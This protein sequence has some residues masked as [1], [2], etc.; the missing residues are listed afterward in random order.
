MRT[1]VDSVDGLHELF[2]QRQVD[3]V[4]VWR[5]DGEVK[6]AGDDLFTIML[7]D[8]PRTAQLCLEACSS[9]GTFVSLRLKARLY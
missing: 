3:Q 2:V 8:K 9:G 6:G 5:V 4:D 1:I 7:I